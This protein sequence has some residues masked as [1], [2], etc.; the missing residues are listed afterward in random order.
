MQCRQAAGLSRM[1]KPMMRYRT[2]ALLFL[3]TAPVA[4]LGQTALDVESRCREFTT[5]DVLPNGKINIPR[6]GDFCWGAFTATQQLIVLGHSGGTPMLRVCPPSTTTRVQLIKVFLNYSQRHPE[7]AH[8]SFG[9]VVWGALD[10]A[11][12]CK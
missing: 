10:E 1:G 4:A 7:L 6:N 9:Q 5:V 11:F 3:L 12:P 8:L 2:A